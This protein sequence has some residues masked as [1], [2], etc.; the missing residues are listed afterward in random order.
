MPSLARVPVNSSASATYVPLTSPPMR[1]V[2]DTM[3]NVP[4]SLHTLLKLRLHKAKDASL[5][6]A[7]SDSSWTT[8]S[9][10]SLTRP[11]TPFASSCT[12]GLSSLL[13]TCTT[14]SGPNC[15]RIPPPPS[16]TSR[17]S[18]R[19]WGGPA[20][21]LP[22]VNGVAPTGVRGGQQSRQFRAPGGHKRELPAVHAASAR[23]GR[24]PGRGGVRPGEVARSATEH[25]GLFFAFAADGWG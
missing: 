1:Y 16:T 8:I 13:N 12:S 7:A 11:A 19:S 14:A 5:T 10:P 18:K 15:S 22:R 24:V 6:L 20:R 23:C 2:L 17:T 25:N 4:V 21:L 3:G 9:S